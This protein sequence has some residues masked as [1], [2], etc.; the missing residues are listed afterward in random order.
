MLAFHL[1]EKIVVLKMCL[2]AF[3][4]AKRYLTVMLAVMP[5]HC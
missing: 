5:P 3:S 4:R 2:G 1:G